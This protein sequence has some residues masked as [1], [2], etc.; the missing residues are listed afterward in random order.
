MHMLR[1]TRCRGKRGHGHPTV[2]LPLRAGFLSLAMLFLLPAAA[3]GQPAGHTAAAPPL[4]ADADETL[5]LIVGTSVV[6]D[7]P[8]TL[9]RVSIADP[10]IADA[11]VVSAREV[12]VNGKRPG[13]T[14]L[15]LWDQAGERTGYTVR[16]TADAATLQDQIELLYPEADIR[17]SASDN[18][19]ILTGTVTDAG[20]EERVVALARSLAR[21]VDLVNQVRVPDRGQVL[22]RVRFAEINRSALDELGPELYTVDEG[23]VLGGAGTGQVFTPGGDRIDEEIPQAGQQPVNFFLFHRPSRVRT[24]FRALQTRGLMRSLA[25]PNLMAVPGDTASFLAGGE[26]PFPVLQTAAGAAGAVTIQFKEFGIRLNFIPTFTNAGDIRLRVAPEV[27]Q[28][29]FADGL[30]VA[31]FR[32]PALL[33]RRAATTIELADGQTFAIAG[34]MDNRLTES[35]NKIPILGDIPILGSL[36][37]SEDI[38]QNRTELLVL[39]TPHIV[40]P[41]DEPPEIPTGEPETWDWV[42]ELKDMEGEELEIEEVEDLLLDP[43]FEGDESQVFEPADAPDDDGGGR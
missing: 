20:I 19:L 1:R 29:S 9:E 37:R 35:I 42:D 39:V 11:V 40:R 13:R 14:T 32:V 36:F 25:E 4:T 30:E 23:N 6:V 3:L 7:H 2:R 41:T 22:L 28:L 18:T 15:L 27:S 43:E 33:T 10:D 12:V 5:T 26:F 8:S 17:V 21:D 31:G 16:V 34:L 38:R 24:F